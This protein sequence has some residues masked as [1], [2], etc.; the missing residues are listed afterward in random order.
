MDKKDKEMKK[1]IIAAFA[2]ASMFAGSCVKPEFVEPTAT[3]QGLTSLEAI[4]TFGPYRDQTMGTLAISDDSQ[5]R[6]VIPIPWFYPETSEDETTPYMTKVRVRAVLEPNYSIEPPITIL[7]LT[8]ENWF[9]LTNP[10]GE[11]HPFCITGERVKSAAC[12]LQAFSI[13]EP[14]IV[15]VIDASSRKVS[16]VSADDLSSCTAQVQISAHATISPDPAEPHDYNSPVEFTVTAHDGKTTSTWT[17]VKEV[18]EK[19]DYGFNST[20]VTPLFNFDPASRLSFP[21]YTETVYPT[22]AMIGSKLVV[23]FGNGTTPVYLN[24]ITGVREGEINLGTATAAAIASD[25]TGNMLICNH[26]AGGETVN[27]WRTASVTEAPV[28]FHSFTNSTD[29]PMGYKMKVIGSIDSDA[30]IVITNEG[31]EGATTSSRFTVITVRSGA[32]E[33]VEVKDITSTGLA[34]STAPVNNTTVVAASPDPADGYYLSYY[35]DNQITWVNG[36]LSIGA[37]MPLSIAEGIASGNYNSN[38]LD[39]KTF[40]N[41]R[42]VAWLITSH[43]PMWGAGPKLYLYDMAN[44]NSIVSNDA[45]LANDSIEWYQQAAAGCAAG[46][47][48]IAPSADGFML[49]IYYYDHNCGVI[50]GY[51]ADCIKR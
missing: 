9:T 10:Q 34:W 17:V 49:Y 23:S 15:G 50:G 25:E 35:S 21:A 3:R 28:L 43:F 44:P 27:I 20:T 42:Y 31:I 5:E 38:T 41:A 33:S 37:Q 26:A 19:I 7:D 14:A 12:D 47:V 29:I 22:M 2:L 4:F 39:S 32:V 6:F 30:Q 48:L 51:S 13:D 8:K 24:S 36:S 40:N 1:T 46:D 18:P 16:L 45:V 11:S